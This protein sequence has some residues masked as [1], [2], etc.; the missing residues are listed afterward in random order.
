[1]KPVQQGVTPLDLKNIRKLNEDALQ[2]RATQ[3]LGAE[4]KAGSQSKVSKE[5]KLSA[6]QEDEV[7]LAGQ[8]EAKA[9]K[10]SESS[11]TAKTRSA[12]DGS[13][14]RVS[15]E[16]AATETSEETSSQSGVPDKPDYTDSEKAFLERLEELNNQA[17][18]LRTMWRKLYMEWYES[19]LKWMEDLENFRQSTTLM[20]QEVSVSRWIQGT[21]HAE[22]ARSLL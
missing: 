10:S 22:A 19:Q 1:M 11:K 20:W 3:N 14:A 2:T 17:K 15:E 16:D 21:K 18:E 7:V 13:S 9:A 5:E 8:P 12:N 4:L 6:G